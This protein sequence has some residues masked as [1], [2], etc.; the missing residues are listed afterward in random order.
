MSTNVALKVKI[1]LKEKI[2]MNTKDKVETNDQTCVLEDL[3]TVNA[4]EIKGGELEPYYHLTMTR[5]FI[6]G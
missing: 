5:V 2:V 4:E 3:T 1:R 6:S